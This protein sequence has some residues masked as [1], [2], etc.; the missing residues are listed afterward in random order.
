MLKRILSAFLLC[1]C[2]SP[3]CGAYVSDSEYVLKSGECKEI[4]SD[5]ESGLPNVKESKYDDTG[6]CVV[7]ECES[8]YKLKD[9]NCNTRTG[10]C[11]KD[12]LPQFATAGVY[13]ADGKCVATQCKDKAYLVVNASGVSQGWCVA[14]VYCQSVKKLDANKVLNIIDNTKTDLSCIDKPAEVASGDAASGGGDGVSGETSTGASQSSDEEYTKP[15]CG[16]CVAMGNCSDK[17]NRDARIDGTISAECDETNNQERRAWGVLQQMYS[18]GQGRVTGVTVKVGDD[19]CTVESNSE[20]NCGDKKYA[21]CT[22][23]EISGGGYKTIT[24]PLNK[25]TDGGTTSSFICLEPENCNCGTDGEVSDANAVVPGDISGAQGA[26]GNSALQN[27]PAKPDGTPCTPTDKNAKSGK[28]QNGECI[29]VECNGAYYKVSDDKKSCVEDKKAKSQ[30]K[31]DELQKNADAMKEKEQSTANKLLGGAAIGATGIGAM[32]AASAY[33]EQQ[34]DEEAEQAMRAYLATFHCNYGGGINVPGGEK[35]VQLPGGNELIDLY[36]E[37]VNLANNLKVRKAALDLR[38]GI[39]SEAILD[40][41]TSGLYDDVAI[42][43]TSGAFT[44]LA[45]AL[46]DPTGEDAKAWAA[47]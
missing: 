39:E 8:G 6:D 36:A 33:S 11:T 23:V 47:Q 17:R 32:Q 40:S 35:D 24:V 34:A 19:T 38:P 1:L 45:R 16:N 3:V 31:I 26:G 41:A 2:V 21:G 25:I 29:I 13:N 27:A 5:C 7:K 18:A 28:Y 37:Y 22:M 20:F 15:T 14:D 30:A 44:S 42:G 43:K 10:N 9:G 4:G 46:Q 12:D